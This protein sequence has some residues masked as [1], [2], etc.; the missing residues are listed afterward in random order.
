MP[1]LR[2]T[3]MGLAPAEL[4]LPAAPPELLDA[5]SASTRSLP[6]QKLFKNKKAAA[7]QPEEVPGAYCSYTF[8]TVFEEGAP[9]SYGGQPWHLRLL[10]NVHPPGKPLR[11]ATADLPRLRG[12]ED[13]RSAGWVLVEVLEGGAVTASRK[14]FR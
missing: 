7:A 13:M 4:T 10:K 1:T 11:R 14:F 9:T 5:L 12:L 3:P 8:H 6:D 2:V